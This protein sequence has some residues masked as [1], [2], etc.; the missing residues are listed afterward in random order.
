MQPSSSSF[1][2]TASLAAMM[3]LQFFVWGSW[4]VTTGNF[5]QAHMA[6]GIA[7]AYSVGPIAAI[8]SPFF[9]GMI[10]DRFF[11]SQKVLAV[12]HLLG[13]AAL[14]AAPS[15]AAGSKDESWVPFVL[16]L[17]LHMLCYMPTLGLTTS[18]S[19][20][21]LQDQEKQFPIVRVFGTVGWIAANQVISNGFQADFT[22]TQ[23]TVAGSAGLLLGV[24]SFFLPHTP[25][26]AAGRPFSVRQA[27]GL[28]ALA[29]LKE[30]AFLVFMVCSFLLCVPLAAYYNRAGIF[31]GSTGVQDVAAKM[32]WG[33]ISEVFFMLVM[34]L[35]FVRLGVKWMLLVGMAAWVVRYAL[36]SFAADD[37]VFWMLM[38][39]ILLHGVCYDFFFVTGMVYVDKRA[40]VEIRAQAQGFL[41]LVTQGLG[42][43]LGAQLVGAMV[44]AYTTSH[45]GGPPG[46][47]TLEVMAWRPFWMIL[48]LAAA[49]I[50]LLFLFTFRDRRAPSAGAGQERA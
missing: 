19:F 40:P 28:D 11:P 30:R 29:L 39:G 31:V 6:G 15:F 34:P 25:P 35:C 27:L 3:F 42:L 4:Y 8:V 5:M 43:G 32:S 18:L 7:W 2:V 46:Q 41:V 24:Y 9:L 47:E 17:G 20:H 1:R 23:Y 45:A 49:A 22:A 33:Q 50:A 14:L 12:M 48:A 13:G 21:N 16:V 26:P 10:A 38:G 44:D 36:F 37:K